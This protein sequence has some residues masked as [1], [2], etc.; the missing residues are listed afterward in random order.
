MKNSMP[1]GKIALFLAFS[2]NAQAAQVLDRV[3]AVVGNQAILASEVTERFKS[4]Q[5]SPT[6]ASIIGVNLADL[7]E[8]RTLEMMIDELMI[9]TLATSLGVP[10]SDTEV[11]QQID[12]IAKQNNI[13]RAQLIQSLTVEGISFD[14]YA[15][16]IKLQIQKRG[17]IERELRNNLQLD[18]AELRKAYQERATREYQI[19]L[20]D[21]PKNIQKSHRGLLSSD[22]WDE[23]AS[24]HDATDLGWVKAASLKSDL[25][26]GLSSA[27]TG[28]LIG[29][30]SFGA[31]NQMVY[32]RAERVGSEEEFQQYKSQIAAQM[33]AAT[34]EARFKT[35][36]EGKREEMN[37]VV[38]S[39]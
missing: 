15:R 5:S 19:V 7:T 34:V 13:S 38:N 17:I 14:A 39:L 10:A 21:L 24:K 25:A 18:D 16:N 11:N 22:K 37:I 31:S 4:L 6:Q 35:W 30:Y 20:L 36:L 33:Q 12:S 27:K 28:E 2:L 23:L 32:L 9:S 3:R 1:I 8:A 29:P 26:S